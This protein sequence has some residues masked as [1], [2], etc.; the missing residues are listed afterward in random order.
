MPPS[1][2]RNRISELANL[3]CEVSIICPGFFSALPTRK[4]STDRKFKEGELKRSANGRALYTNPFQL[5]Q[6]KESNVDLNPWVIAP[7]SGDDFLKEHHRTRLHSRPMDPTH[8]GSTRIPPPWW[9][10]PP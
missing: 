6:V 3:L 7:F 4:K 10:L 2:G 9:H 8:L 1:E 5:A